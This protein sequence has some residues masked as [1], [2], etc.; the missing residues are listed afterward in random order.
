MTLS[1]ATTATAFSLSEDLFWPPIPITRLRDVLSL[2][3][4]I[5]EWQLKL[6]AEDTTSKIH[7]ALA[8]W[9]SYV[10]QQGYVCLEEVPAPRINHCS[11]LVT[12]YLSVVEALIILTLHHNLNRAECG[13][14]CAFDLQK[15]KSLFPHEY[16]YHDK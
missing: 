7:Q 6:A 5:S 15:M 8:T 12:H 1:T 11:L 9:C 14:T 2:S 13:R 3:P 16:R 10:Q 4:N